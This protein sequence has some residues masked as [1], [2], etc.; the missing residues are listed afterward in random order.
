MSM[1]R[2]SKAA[3]GLGVI[4]VL[5]A[6]GTANA[7]SSCDFGSGLDA[8]FAAANA[9]G[10]ITVTVSEITNVDY[11][12]DRLFIRFSLGNELP[13]L[14]NHRTGYCLKVEV[15]GQT[16]EE[17]FDEA[18]STAR[19]GFGEHIEIGPITGTYVK[20]TA[21]ARVR[22]YEAAYTPWSSGFI[23]WGVD[24]HRRG[25]SYSN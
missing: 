25:Y 19:G 1:K 23:N 17:C 15:K 18:P 11:S 5:L 14:A 16:H 13:C 3:A 2:M 10:A 8:A 9:V 20:T 12:V 21:Y 4:A 7:Q 24:Y 22:Y 6:G